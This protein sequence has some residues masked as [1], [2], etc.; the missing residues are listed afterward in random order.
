MSSC[1]ATNANATAWSRRYAT[2]S[3]ALAATNNE[4]ENP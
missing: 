2:R 4:E 1:R 3:D